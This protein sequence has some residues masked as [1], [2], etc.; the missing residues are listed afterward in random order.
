MM[1]SSFIELQAMADV[2]E[3]SQDWT[4]L[5]ILCCPLPVFEEQDSLGWI[6]RAPSV[7]MEDAMASTD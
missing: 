4:A 2:P 3:K 6:K 1:A 7:R 5:A